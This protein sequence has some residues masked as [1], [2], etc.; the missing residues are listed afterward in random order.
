M[1]QSLEFDFNFSSCVR[2]FQLM[3][4]Q[5][6]SLQ[7]L[8]VIGAPMIST[9]LADHCKSKQDLGSSAFGR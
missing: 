6:E 8:F 3:A 5:F 9:S 4:A 7:Q 2:F 1:V